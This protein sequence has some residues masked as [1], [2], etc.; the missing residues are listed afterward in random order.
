MTATGHCLCG[1][2][3]FTAE[4]VETDIH[5]CHCSMCR[6]WAGG[7]GFA[8]GVGSVQFSG[9][10]LITRY[11]SSAWAERG[12][13]SRCG[14]NLFYRLKDA[15]HY[16]LQMGT[17]DDQSSFKVSGEI[18][19]DEKPAGYDLAGDHPRM[20]GEEFMASLQQNDS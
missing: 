20:T 16:I 2:V 13:C 8:A 6:R 4:D 18:Y 1:A 3:S 5:T 17:F 19:I 11:D 12:F 7:P 10:E 9:E 14:S 15:N